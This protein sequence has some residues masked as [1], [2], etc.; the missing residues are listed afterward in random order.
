MTWNIG[1][2]F[3]LRFASAFCNPFVTLKKEVDLEQ[4]VEMGSGAA[5]DSDSPIGKAGKKAKGKAR[6]KGKGKGKAK[7]S[8]VAEGV[9]AGVEKQL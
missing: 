3:A 2:I 7:A 1:T 6:T 4:R 9:R 8:V 5:S